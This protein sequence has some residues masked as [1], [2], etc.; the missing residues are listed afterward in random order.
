ML[1]S[2]ARLAAAR[3]AAAGGALLLRRGA[4]AFVSAN[5]PSSSLA[6]R[7]LSS[8]ASPRANAGKEELDELDRIH[9]RGMTF[10]G[11]HGVFPEVN[12]CSS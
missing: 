11:Y 12:D 4:G 1:L 6:A 9:M 3:R 10:H 2:L 7:P 8:S 5:T